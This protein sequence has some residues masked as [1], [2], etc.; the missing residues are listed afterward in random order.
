MGAFVVIDLTDRY[1]LESI[2]YWVKEIRDN[3]AADMP[4]MVI[5]NKMDLVEREIQEDDVIE[6]F[7]EMQDKNTL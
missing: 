1:S 3:C 2:D 5:G 7:E 4:I 6:K